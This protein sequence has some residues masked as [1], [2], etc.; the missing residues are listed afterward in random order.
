MEYVIFTVGN[1]EFLG[2][3]MNGVAAITTS[4]NFTTLISIGLLFGCL[5]TCWECVM[6]GTRV[7]NLQ[8]MLVAFCAYLCMFGP[9]R[10]VIIQDVYNA[11]TGDVVV[12]NI[13]LGVAAS[14]SIVSRIGYGICV[15]IETAYHPASSVATVYQ[16][17]FAEPLRILNQVRTFDY[18]PSTI[19]AINAK[20][21]DYTPYG[22]TKT[23]KSDYRQ[24]VNNYIRDC[25]YPE[26][27][28]GHKSIDD[29]KTTPA[30]Q[31]P[32]KS[33]SGAFH[34]YLPIKGDSG[35]T[36]KQ[37]YSCN[38]G[39]DALQTAFNDAFE[40]ST[41]QTT[42]A[43]G[44]GGSLSRGAVPSLANFS[45]GMEAIGLTG[46]NAQEITKNR[47]INTVLDSAAAGHFKTMQDQA[48]AVATMSAIDQRNIQW[49]SEGTMFTQ[50][51]HALMT[52]IEGFCY[53]IMPIMAFVFVMG[54]LGMRIVGKYFQI[55]LWIQLWY[56]IMAIVNL[57]VINSTKTAL[58][59]YATSTSFYDIGM[60]FHEVE[61]HLG[62]AGLMLGATPLLALLVI[63]GS[64][65]A[66]TAIAG[67]MGGQDHFN[68]RSIQPDAMQVGP[69]M[70]T[71]A[72]ANTT[73]GYG[74]RMSGM[75]SF[76]PTIN[77]SD[78]QSAITAFTRNL[79]TESSSVLSRTL[80]S[81]NLDTASQG[82]ATSVN[83][84][85][86][87][88][89]AAQ[90]QET[91]QAMASLARKMGY[92]SGAGGSVTHE[93]VGKVAALADGGFQ[94]KLGGEAAR[95][96]SLGAGVKGEMTTS[97]GVK[98][99][100]TTKEN[101]SKED[102]ATFNNLK[103]ASLSKAVQ[104]GRSKTVASSDSLTRSAIDSTTLG[105]NLS[106]TVR[107]SESLSKS[108]NAQSHLG[109]DTKLA[110]DALNTYLNNAH[111]NM[112]IEDA[113]QN[114]L[115]D[116]AIPQ[117]KRDALRTRAE[118]L[119]QAKGSSAKMGKAIAYLE[120]AMRP[121]NNRTGDA[122]A[123]LAGGGIVGFY[124]DN[125]LSKSMPEPEKVGD[126]NPLGYQGK[127]VRGDVEKNV[128]KTEG[129]VSTAT[130]ETKELL[131]NTGGNPDAHYSNGRKEVKD[132]DNRNQGNIQHKQFKSSEKSLQNAKTP[133]KAT[134]MQE[135]A[136]IHS[137]WKGLADKW[138]KDLTSGLPT[139][140][141]AGIAEYFVVSHG[142]ANPGG[143]PV[144]AAKG[145]TDSTSG[146]T[147]VMSGVAQHYAPN[148][149]F[150]ITEDYRDAE[151]I[152]KNAEDAMVKD[153]VNAYRAHYGKDFS[154][155]KYGD[156]IRQTV[157]GIKNI[158]K[159]AFTKDSI[160]QVNNFLNHAYRRI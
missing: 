5:Y 50:S 4:E 13:P 121:E 65:M 59:P 28:M 155:E 16:G 160:L 130:R 2:A 48:T 73:F 148:V 6:N 129:E 71:M 139:G 97:D 81:Q 41:V 68:E 84:N 52:F 89:I 94:I 154:M 1:A 45:E 137:S 80:T 33:T 75:E 23:V 74:T 7:F 100:F 149:K 115:R 22:S 76:I 152:K 131:D 140:V 61:T 9:T 85:V 123:I 158:G 18:G 31:N 90:S 77:V 12:D 36:D 83:S 82:L 19:R 124:G 105:K 133:T 142:I 112:F 58:K 39:Y 67:R 25:T 55:L 11:G 63:T 108:E 24:A 29:I 40:D 141:G 21:G 79:L 91:Y 107:L 62:V 110:S 56:P 60:M 113:Y 102:I 92:A 109:S 145:F 46:I 69:V 95:L 134:S 88:A 114:A 66:F 111:N 43:K 26:I 53:A 15:L 27:Q 42:M 104:T 86:G 35:L 138:R 143:M 126:I 14:G 17:G 127:S 106:E 159:T 98:R 78:A 34:V 144:E 118:S 120:F 44:I 99:E 70:N 153:V 136:A 54:A 51:M 49:A 37:V 87:A 8:H 10:T 93:D 122:Q 135:D 96:G 3:I 32:F 146:A 72:G 47:I 132:A 38:K 20:L 147:D 116:T 101:L 30:S 151:T 117:A 150:G 119:G 128:K 57:Y 125:N 103:S 64:S 157:Q 156:D